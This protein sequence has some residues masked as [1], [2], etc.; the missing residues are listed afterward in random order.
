MNL[1]FEEIKSITFGAIDIINKEDGVHF[2][3]CSQKQIDAWYKLRTDLGE[4]A[5]TTTGVT[6]DFHTNS[7]NVR[8]SVIGDKYELL[9]NG[10]LTQQIVSEPV[11]SQN[12]QVI[13]V[14]LSGEEQ[15]VTLVFPSHG[16]G[17]LRSI[18]VDKGAYVH[19][20]Q[21]DEKILFIG[22]SI[23]QGWD[24]KFDCM[25][26]AH[27][28][29]SFYNAERVINGIG[30]AI[31]HPSTFDRVQF[32]PNIVIVAYGTNDY[33]Y[34]QGY[35]DYKNSVVSYLEMIEEA[36][37]G[38]NV[39]IITPIWRFDKDNA[40]PIGTFEKCRDTIKEESERLG[41]ISVDGYELVPHLESFYA[42]IVHPNELGFGVYAEKLINKIGEQVCTNSLRKK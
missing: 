37:R 40:R 21:F 23:T 26:F 38:K 28:V 10:M 14:E 2:M 9:V 33:D 41:F 17:I 11:A 29:A 27:R 35:E 20:H 36:Y 13:H 7:K 22:D 12:E 3:K 25:S 5:E 18:S 4:R 39:F 16:V 8:F 32:E 15:R 24:S 34:Y 30:G 19:P 6:I 1:T 42:D 31:Y